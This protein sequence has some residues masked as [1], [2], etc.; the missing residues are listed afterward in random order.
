LLPM[1]IT[2]TRSAILLIIHYSND[3]DE[4]KQYLISK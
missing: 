3:G 2:I 4:L 1:K